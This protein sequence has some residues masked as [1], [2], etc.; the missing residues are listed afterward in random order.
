MSKAEELLGQHQKQRG[1]DFT[2][3]V[4]KEEPPKPPANTGDDMDDDALLKRIQKTNPHIKSLDDLKPPPPAPLTAEE[5]EEQK[6]QRKKAALEYGLTH[7]IV[8]PDEIVAFERD[9]QTNEVELA[10]P[11]YLAEFRENIKGTDEEDAFTDDD[12]RKEFDKEYG[13]DAVENSPR[14]KNGQKKL[15]NFKKSHIESTY[16]KVIGLDKTFDEYESTINKATQY[17]GVV[18]AVFT[19]LPPML[20]FNLKGNEIPFQPTKET[21]AAVKDLYLNEN[22]FKM[23]KDIPLTKEAY[24]AAIIK[25]LATLDLDNLLSEVSEKYFETESRKLGLG[26]QGIPE[27]DVIG[28][29][30]IT[31]QQAAGAVKNSNAAA[32]LEKHKKDH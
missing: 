2:P 25:S 13:L 14:W 24:N 32:R 21:L 18:E 10:F 27:R 6:K 26:R 31:N 17:K 15:S 11:A 12:I 7:E 8:A 4:K 5:L 9:Q 23:F 29:G 1:R 22:A 30:N 16:S 20:T 28:E 19:E 3:I